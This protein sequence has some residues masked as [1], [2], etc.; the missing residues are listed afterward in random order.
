MTMKILDRYIAKTVLGSIGLV[1]L[2]LIG[3]QIFILFVDQ[4]SDLG[5][6]DFGIVQATFFVMLQMPYQVYLFFPMASLLGTLIGL[7]I[8]A[9]HSELVIMRA[10]GMSIGQ[11]T[12]AVLKASVLLIVFV[13]VLGETLVPYL[14]HY[15]NDYKTAAISGGQT[16]RTSKGFWLRYNN[17]FISVGL[18]LSNNVLNNIYQFRFDN[19]HHLTMSRFIREVRHTP[20]GWVAY[21]VQQTEFGDDQTKAQTFASFPWDVSVKPKILTIS[22]IDPDEMNLRELNRY[23]REQKLNHQN[24]HNYQFAF[25]QRLIQPFTTMVMMILSIPF[26]F[27]PLRSTTM[28]SKLLVG[29]AVGFSFHIL[30]RFFGP[31]ST[32]FQLPPELSALGPTVIFA[33][34]GLYL[35]R[36]VR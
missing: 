7:G 3:L 33:L 18:V 21:D 36:R 34:L 9:N 10:S 28:G 5:R 25:L 8:L 11:I 35:M 4:I 1:T 14:S 31:L 24:V 13:T 22:S 27:G 26:I 30:N 6:V 16:L 19:Q 20:T 15:A 23:I 29:A 12:W 2:M 32:V 17:D